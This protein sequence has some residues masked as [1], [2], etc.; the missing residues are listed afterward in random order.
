MCL[1][2]HFMNPPIA[3]SV[4]DI[5]SQRK[6][7]WKLKSKCRKYF[8]QN[9]KSIQINYNVGRCHLQTINYKVQ[10]TRRASM[11]IFNLIL[12]ATTSTK[13]NSQG[14]YYTVLKPSL[15]Q[16]VTQQ[17]EVQKS[18]AFLFL[19]NNL[20]CFHCFSLQDTS[21]T[22]SSSFNHLLWTSA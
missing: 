17:G 13:E 7:P 20:V 18:T 10:K 11:L 5:S 2:K 14:G 6:I 3:I 8:F 19:P 22:A 1:Y 21:L 15:G 12:L 4:K 16:H 9:K